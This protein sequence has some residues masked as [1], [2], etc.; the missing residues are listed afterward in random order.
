MT[1]TQA[2]DSGEIW[3]K[4]YSIKTEI[5]AARKQIGIC[6]QFDTFLDFP[7]AREHLRMFAKIRGVTGEEIGRVVDNIFSRLDLQL[8]ADI[9]CND[10]SDH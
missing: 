9:P 6:P 3:I 7:S 10:Y 1:G 2:M 8:K 5:T 4:N